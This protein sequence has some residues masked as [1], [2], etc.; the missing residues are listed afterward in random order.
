MIVAFQGEHGA[1]SDDVASQFF[2]GAETRGFDTFDALAAAVA[3][4]TAD[5]AVMPVENSISGSIPRV[6]DLLWAYSDLVVIDEIVYR[7]V[8]NLIAVPGT[9]LDEIREVRS[10]QVAL[11]QCRGFLSKH[12]DWHRVIVADTA[13]AVRAMMEAGDPSSAA[14][15]SAIAARRYGAEL[16]AEGIQDIP[17][18][19]TRFLL[20]T[21]S[22]SA[23]RDLRRACIALTLANRPGSL[24]EALAAF[25]EAKLNLRS[26]VSRPTNDDPF[27]YRFYCEVENVTAETLGA[28]LARIDGTSR[29]LGLY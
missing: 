14:I 24:H 15:A 27:T 10:H 9:K 8:Q 3:D 12:P 23:R 22:G 2:P 20:V 13:G 5:F 26:L 25:A 6:Y 18:N 21:R 29:I 1:F 7:V 28:A 11:E 19:F 16:L 17:N 4:G